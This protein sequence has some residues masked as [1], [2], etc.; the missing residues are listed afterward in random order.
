MQ[1]FNFGTMLYL[2][3]HGVKAA[4]ADRFLAPWSHEYHPEFY[5]E[6]LNYLQA[7]EPALDTSPVEKVLKEND[8]PGDVLT[9][10]RYSLE[11]MDCLPVNICE[12]SMG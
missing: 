12:V 7:V 11:D 1:Y 6:F 3:C 8:Y 2:A 10:Y 4:V 9:M 5:R